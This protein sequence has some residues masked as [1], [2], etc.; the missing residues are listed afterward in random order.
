MVLIITHKEDYTSDFVI[1][2]LNQRNLKYFRL[3]CEDLITSDYS[4][5][6][7]LLFSINGISEFKS[8]WFRRTKLPNLD[9]VDSITQQYLLNEFDALLKNIFCIIT[10][11][12]VSD[13]YSIYKAENKLLQLKEAKRLGFNIPNTILTNS[14][15]ELKKFYQENDG[16]IIIKPLSQSKILNQNEF[17]FL[18]TNSLKKEHIEDIENFDLTPCLYQEN[19]NKEIEL[20]V[21][22]VANQIFIAGVDSQ[23][24]EETKID[25]RKAE[26]KFF[27][28]HLPKEI[29]DKCF[30]IVRALNLNFGAIDL[31]KD[32]NGKYI[33]L[34]INPNGQWAWIENETGLEI[35]EALISELY[36]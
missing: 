1:N 24:R 2:K 36:E 33:F 11:K 6:K 16:N 25:W 12:W 21:T 30:S 26:L 3:N 15:Q 29:I 14:K 13:P 31:I 5:N 35:S 32:K 19:I 22:I 7:E 18:F 9:N 8:V 4:I 27:K 10:A 34:E 20:R 28:T 17:E 23:N